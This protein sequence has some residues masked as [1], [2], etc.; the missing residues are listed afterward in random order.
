MTS[1]QLARALGGISVGHVLG[2]FLVLARVSPLFL[3]APGFSSQMLIA[4]ARSVLAV[5]IALGIAPLAIHGQTIPTEIL[6]YAGLVVQN[7][8]VGLA[9]AFSISCVFA[10][11]QGAG[12]LADAF[13][14]F[15]FGSQIDPING[16]PGGTMTNIYAVVGLAMF[17]AIGGEAWTLH[18]LSATFNAVP[19]A[20]SPQIKPLA[21]SAEAAF[22]SLFVGAIEIAA[23]VILAII[24]TDIAFGMVSKVVPQ[25]NVFAVGFTVKVGVTLLVVSVS[26]PFIGDWMTGQLETSV[27]TALQSL[28]IA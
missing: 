13:G 21:Y 6:P 25:L 22:S 19:I 2:Y 4:R 20:D 12:V 26:L 14:G 17:L 9:L 24:V 15:S 16:N 10:A 27:A 7:F 3:V 11:V 8:L 28:R 23:P 5:G 18:G 1:A